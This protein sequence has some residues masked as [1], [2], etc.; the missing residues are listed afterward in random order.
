M[1]SLM[2]CDKNKSK[3]SIKLFQILSNNTKT[4]STSDEISQNRVEMVRF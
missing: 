4:D 1:Y 3:K 2:L